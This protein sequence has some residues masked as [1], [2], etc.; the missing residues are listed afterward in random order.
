MANTKH[1]FD[2]EYNSGTWDPLCLKC[3]LGW[4]ALYN[5]AYENYERTNIGET[6]IEF[7][8][9]TVPCITDEEAAIKRLLE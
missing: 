7:I 6:N 9:R 3:K 4:H 2:Y 5:N 1:S 8:N